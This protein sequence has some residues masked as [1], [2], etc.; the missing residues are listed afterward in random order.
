VEHPQNLL[1]SK[2]QE[3]NIALRELVTGDPDHPDTIRRWM[4]LQR[5]V[6]VLF[7]SSKGL[8][9]YSISNIL[10]VLFLFLLQLYLV[11]LLVFFVVLLITQLSMTLENFF[12][13]HH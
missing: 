2:V 6:T 10:C 4:D 5:S 12:T 11:R 1:L 7:D 8:S 9:M 3:S 13:W